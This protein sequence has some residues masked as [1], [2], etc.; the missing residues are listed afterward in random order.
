[1]HKYR[2]QGRH[3]SG[4]TAIELMVTLSILGILI[5]IAAPS[6]TRFVAQ[7]RVSN[8]VNSFTGALRIARTEA[9]ARSR[10]VVLCRVASNTSTSCQT[11]IG[12]NGLASGWIVFVDMDGNATFSTAGGDELLLRQEALSGID[13]IEPT[14]SS[15]PKFTFYPSGLSNKPAGFNFDAAGFANTSIPDWARKGIC[16][17]KS[18][19]IRYVADSAD[20]G[21]NEQP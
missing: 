5:A 11:T 18:G 2:F 7:W 8:A 6:M 17:T 12:T 10:P 14:D 15:M 13:S 9:I 4:L 1:M 21:T 3:Q 16:M 20:C 19:R